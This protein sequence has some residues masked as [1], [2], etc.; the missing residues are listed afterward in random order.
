MQR[1]GKTKEILGTA[2]ELPPALPVVG[3]KFPTTFREIFG[4]FC[5]NSECLFTYLFHYFSLK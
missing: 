5:G 1:K 4:I 2:R 3:K